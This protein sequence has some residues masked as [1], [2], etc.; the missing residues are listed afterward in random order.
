VKPTLPIRRS[1]LKL[2]PYVPPEE[3]RAEK[4]RLDFNENTVGSSRAACRAL[5]RLTPL[6]LAMYTEYDKTTR[7]LERFFGVRQGELLL[8]NGADDA[9]RTAFDV[10]VDPGSA[11]VIPEPTFNM[12]RF[13]AEVFGARVIAP[14]Y[15]AELSFPM[16]EVLAA[17][18]KR[19][20]L[21]IIANPNN[22]T[23]TLLGRAE[24]EKILK[25]AGHTAVI[26]DEAYVEYSGL[27]VVPWIR[28]YPH[29]VVI[30]T[31]SKAAGLAGLRLGALIAHAKLVELFRRVAMP[32]AVNSAA[33]VA[34][35]AA[36]RDRR[37][38][39]RYIAEVLKARREFEAA[40]QKLEFRTYPSA[41]NFIIVDFGADGPRLVRQL[42][43]ENILVRDRSAAFGRT[44]PV[45]I[46]IG[47]R[48]EMRRVIAAI[49]RHV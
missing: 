22:P 40:L 3:G 41:G 30:R 36:I 16:N 44:G 18:K 5:A 8:T 14:R 49:K 48:K 47:T 7:T 37:A 43:R 29:L 25:A 45:R 9:L 46:S 32:F 13:Y 4:L 27:T 19:P 26:V 42:A 15:D 28:R 10:F 11:V 33:L 21:L 24:L 6:D 20:R 38:I 2:Q 39:R 1:V 34:A 12:Y 23:G 17:L 35:E 31:F